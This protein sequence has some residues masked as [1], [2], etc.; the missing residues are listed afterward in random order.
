M[1]IND[2]EYIDVSL[3]CLIFV[4][5]VKAIKNCPNISIVRVLENKDK[6]KKNVSRRAAL[7][8]A[9][10][11]VEYLLAA[12]HHYASKRTLVRSRKP[13]K[14]CHCDRCNCSAA[15]SL[16]SSPLLTAPPGLLSQ[17]P[18]SIGYAVP[19]YDVCI[20]AV[21]SACELYGERQSGGCIRTG[22]S[23]V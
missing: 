6:E 20:S 4:F 13:V 19:N 17:V 12:T 3:K 18:F 15:I 22:A 14:V 23:V 7:V 1:S 21:Q 5:S 9:T 16:G 11:N 8:A 10:P 2:R